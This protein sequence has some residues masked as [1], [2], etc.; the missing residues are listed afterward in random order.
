MTMYDAA[1]AMEKYGGSF[2]RA[3]AE[4]WFTADPVNRRKLEKC[5]ADLFEMY[6]DPKWRD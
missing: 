5:F 2:A 4:A 3:I 1:L 6:D